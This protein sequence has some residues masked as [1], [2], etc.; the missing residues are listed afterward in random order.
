[1]I[2]K[3]F[4]T[5]CLIVALFCSCED[6]IGPA[7]KNSL[8]TITDEV[9]GNNCPNGGQK[10]ESGVDV[11]GNG[12]LGSTEVS[13]TKYVCNGQNGLSTLATYKDEPA[14]NNCAGGGFKLQIGQ[15]LNGNLSL[16][17]N[18]IQSTKYI[19]LPSGD[20]QTRLEIGES[21]NST[22]STDWYSASF[23]T[24]RLIKFN[25]LN[26]SNVDS[27]TFVPS[28]YTSDITN[29]VY[30][31]LYNWTDNVEI[32]NTHMSSNTKDWIFKESVNIYDQL[33]NK[34][35]T[36]GIRFKSENSS[37]YVSTGIRSYLFIYKH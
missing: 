15:D 12:S 1:M 33:P 36:L 32:N 13:Q 5:Q 6:K 23:Q 4:F 16:D 10:I 31:E 17:S 9:A 37:F 35:I 26:Y 8:V 25:K 18:E 22:S 29:K 14:G 24:Y 20:K 2:L 3:R 19:C 28:L 30:V 7:G 11:D 21:N 34:E 27:I